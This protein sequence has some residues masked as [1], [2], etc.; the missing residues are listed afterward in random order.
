[1][2]NFTATLTILA[3]GLLAGF[4]SARAQDQGYNQIAPKPAPPVA[5]GGQVTTPPLPKAPV[6]D[7][8]LVL[9]KLKALVFVPSPE[10]VDHGGREANEPIVL[11]KVNLP[12]ETAFRKLVTPYVGKP[13]T[14]GQMNALITSI[15]VF[16]RQ[17]DRPIV[18]VIVPVQK[19]TNGVIQIVILEGKVGEVTVAGN[20]WFPSGEIRNGLQIQSGDS[21]RASRMQADLDWI[22]QNPFHSSDLVYEP[23][24]KLGD[25]NLIL[26]TKDRFPARFY[27]GYED[28]G[29][30]ATGFDRYLTG[31]NWGDAFGLGLGQQLDYQY[32]TSGNGEGLQAHSGSYMIPLPWHHNLTFF[33][34][35]ADTKGSIPPLVDL[36]GT[37]YQV[38][39]RY[40][41]PLPILTWPSVLTYRETVGAGFDYKY[42]KNSL[43]FGGAPVPGTLYDVDQFVLTYNGA[44]TD[45][46]GQTTVNEQLYLSPGNWGGNNNDA[47]FNAAHTGATSDYVYNTIVLERLT[48][49]P[50]DF[51][52][53]LRGTVQSSNGNLAPSE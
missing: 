1:M 17:Y 7:S 29:N 36:T 4:L 35:Y 12:D 49:L 10:A 27:A 37:T 34:S 6:N 3:A 25:T 45:V 33:G 23:G 46:Y 20:R 26:Q 42:N 21:I 13:F 16:Y 48:R 38:S 15:V 8:R 40:D 18:D 22:N 47:A 53:V 44:E 24:R 5:P 32:T 19:I 50:A 28:S 30:A 41:I 43:L 51:T 2:K 31:L 11:A 9:K 52:L 14:R 39:G